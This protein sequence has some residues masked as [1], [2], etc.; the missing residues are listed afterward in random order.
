VNLPRGV[1][2]EVPTS[3]PSR[4]QEGTGTPGH[5]WRVV[6]EE[7]PGVLVLEYIR[8]HVPSR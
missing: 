2:R 5:I 8:P 1:D 4:S 6:A 7:A 3:H